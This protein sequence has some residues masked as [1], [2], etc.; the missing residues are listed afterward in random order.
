MIVHK[1]SDQTALYIVD[2]KPHRFRFMKFI[3]NF[4]L[5][6]K[7]IR[8]VLMQSDFCRQSRIVV[9]NSGGISTL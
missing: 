3:G 8:I 4:G 9:L 7:G 6:I 5:H 2:G 1:D